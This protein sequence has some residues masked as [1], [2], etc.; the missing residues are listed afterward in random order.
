MKN[1]QGYGIVWV[2]GGW[3]EVWMLQEKESNKKD[4]M[5]ELKQKC[6][7][8]TVFIEQAHIDESGQI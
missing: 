7:K 6:Q 1:A 2:E 8:A 5:R 4:Q 3:D